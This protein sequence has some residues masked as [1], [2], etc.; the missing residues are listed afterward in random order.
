MVVD[1]YISL[2]AGGGL[3]RVHKF[4]GRGRRGIVKLFLDRNMPA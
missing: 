3:R 4:G 1:L 2:G